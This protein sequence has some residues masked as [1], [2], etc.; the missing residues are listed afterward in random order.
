MAMGERDEMERVR[1][2]GQR[3]SRYWGEMMVTGRMASLVIPDEYL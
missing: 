3:G 1:E 2:R